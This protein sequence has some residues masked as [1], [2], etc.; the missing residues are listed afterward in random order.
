MTHKDMPPRID[1]QT[2]SFRKEG[3]PDSATIPR[4]PLTGFATLF[5]L[6]PNTVQS[7]DFIP[8]N[9]NLLSATPRPFLCKKRANFINLLKINNLEESGFSA[10]AKL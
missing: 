6:R 1:P 8:N 2:T 10:D 3:A 9:A 5:S 7:P 4:P